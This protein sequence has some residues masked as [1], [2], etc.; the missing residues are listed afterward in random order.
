ML[1]VEHHPDLTPPPPAA[2]YPG[3]AYQR[4]LSRVPRLRLAGA[5]ALSAAA[6]P[7]AL[8]GALMMLRSR[9]PS[10]LHM[11]TL[12]AGLAGLTWAA[13]QMHVA[14]LPHP[15]WRN[16]TLHAVILGALSAYFIPFYEWW[17]HFP[18][19]V[20]LAANILIM[21]VSVFLLLG[22]LN[23]TAW[24]LGEAL[25]DETLR[26]EGL[27][28]IWISLLTG[29]IFILWTLVSVSMYYAQYGY[30]VFPFFL[31]REWGVAMLLPFALTS[32]VMIKAA[33]RAWQK[34]GEP[35]P[36]DPP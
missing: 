4:A 14:R 6:T 31:L 26:L 15:Q 24:M 19:S 22:R 11:V 21:A 5:F 1:Q 25:E 17:I 36:Q 9:A 20:Y 27:A 32:A 7:V 8:V 16:S 3:E 12:A 33:R 13:W 10:A 34:I 29:S 2:D 30:D 28:G 18:G 23:K 35:L